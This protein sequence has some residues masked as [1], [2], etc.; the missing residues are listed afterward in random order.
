MNDATYYNTSEMSGHA[1]GR[2]FGLIEHTYRL[3]MVCVGRV[4]W[5]LHLLQVKLGRGDEVICIAH[6]PQIASIQQRTQ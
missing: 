3:S 4:L 6:K 1:A 5:P 2:R